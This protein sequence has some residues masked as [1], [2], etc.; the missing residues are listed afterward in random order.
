MPDRAPTTLVA[1]ISHAHFWS[2]KMARLLPASPTRKVFLFVF[3]SLSFFFF[4]PCPLIFAIKGALCSNPSYVANFGS[5][6]E[7]VGNCFNWSVWFF[8]TSRQVP[9]T[10]NPSNCAGCVPIST[11]VN[12]SSTQPLTT[13]GV[14][15]DNCFQFQSPTYVYPLNDG[16][17]R[18]AYITYRFGGN[19][20]VDD[21]CFS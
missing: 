4:P 12:A 8:L 13:T 21:C 10:A 1:R 3:A 11:G 7:S 17:G 16:S 20:V 9:S 6:Y 18:T 14:I 5:S 2:S 15:A 19:F